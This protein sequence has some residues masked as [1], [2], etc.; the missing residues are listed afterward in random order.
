MDDN[1]WFIWPSASRSETLIVQ[2]KN[3][4]HGNI[5]LTV[6]EVAEEIKISTGSCHTILMEDLGMHRVLAKCVPRLDWWT[7]TVTI[8]HLS[9]SPPNCITDETWVYSY[10][11]E[12]TQQS[13]HLMSPASPSQKKA[14]QVCP[15]VEAVLLVF[16]DCRGTVH[17]EFNPK[18]QTIKTVIWRYWDACRMW[19]L[20]C[21][22]WEAG[23]SIT[24]M[25]LLTQCC[26]LDNRQFLAPPHP[27]HL[28]TLIST[29]FY[30]LKLKITLKGRRFQTVKGI[31]T[32]AT[33]E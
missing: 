3:I 2:V 7:E 20:K 8:F 13:S 27:I 25:H 19:D 30:S 28:T 5:W 1:E 15:G 26:Q 12:T 11:V 22:L 33:N 9:K 6:R 23:S 21:G 4:I 29:F 32:N 24:I 18:D 14:P 16:F 31:I 10:D 17:Y